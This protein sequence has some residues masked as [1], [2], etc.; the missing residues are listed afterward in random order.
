MDNIKAAAKTA[1]IKVAFPEPTDPKML[2]AARQA[3]DEGI[4]IPFLVGSRTQIL[5]NA[6]RNSI[7]L[8]NMEL[9]NTDDQTTLT[10]T[11]RAYCSTHTGVSE[12]AMLRK[13]KNWMYTAMM[14]QEIGCADT[15]F[16][17][18]SCSTGDV[19]LA[20]QLVIGLKPGI[21]TISSFGIYDIPGYSGPE[22]TLL[23]FGDSAVCVNPDSSQLAD[24]A[25]SCCDSIQK[26]C[27]WEP[28]CALL[29]Y[30]TDGSAE[31][32]LVEKVREAV[33]LARERRPDLKIDGEFQLDSAINPEI[34]LKKVKR[35]S[36][37]AGNANIII[38]PDLNAGNIGVKLIQQFAHGNAYGPSLQG[39]NKVVSDCSRS[40]SVSELVGNIAMTCVLAS[41]DRR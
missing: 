22:G 19:I 24:I 21:S 38:W 34:A 32:P 20:A 8:E 12:K 37:V 9:F 2:Q 29:S 28:R 1:R 36:D 4:C 10:E 26:L 27:G 11:I 16:A 31:S 40:A 23:G 3:C 41:K 25:I 14:L 35:E 39:F 6:S 5:E 15:T 30:S 7:S 18:I 33:I 17:G 13:S